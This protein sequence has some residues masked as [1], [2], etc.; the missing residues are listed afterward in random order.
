MLEQWCSKTFS[1]H[2]I[3]FPLPF[4]GREYMYIWVKRVVG[5]YMYLSK[6]SAIINTQLLVQFWITTLIICGSVEESN[7]SKR[8]V[9]KIL[10]YQ[11]VQP[12]F[13]LWDRAYVRRPETQEGEVAC[14]CQ[15]VFTFFVGDFFEKQMMTS[16]F[17][18][19]LKTVFCFL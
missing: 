4:W 6:M 2:L 14:V 9:T 17:L 1:I 16:L 19:R 5:L 13:E 12:V 18:Y 7:W 11:C 3:L 15:K 8:H 10:L